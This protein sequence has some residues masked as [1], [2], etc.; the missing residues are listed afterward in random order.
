MSGFIDT[1]RCMY[2]DP[3]PRLLL[4]AEHRCLSLLSLT[5]LQAT[6]ARPDPC[7][8]VRILNLWYY[9]ESHASSPH[10]NKSVANYFTKEPRIYHCYSSIFP[11]GPSA[12]LPLHGYKWKWSK[13]CYGKFIAQKMRTSKK[14]VNLWNILSRSNW[15]LAIYYLRGYI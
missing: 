7:P 3:C 1:R 12:W 6:Y 5:Q 8:S 15:E 14:T 11:A 2:L 9:V 10:S 4:V 13:G